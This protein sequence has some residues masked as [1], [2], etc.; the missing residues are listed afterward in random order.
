MIYF[1]V[2]AQKVYGVKGTSI[3][4]IF[5]WLD[6]L[7]F[8]AQVGGGSMIDP[9][10]SIKQQMLGIHIYMGGIGFQEFC[11]LLFLTIAIKFYLMM[12]VEERQGAFLDGRPKN[13]RMLLF[14]LF[15]A[16]VLI[17]IRIIF[18][19]VEF[20]SGLEA[21]KNPIPFH[22][23]YFM[24]LD[25]LPMTI[26]VLIFNV[27]HPGRVLQG[28]G[29]EFPKGPSRK[30]KKEIKRAKKEAKQMAKEE[31]KAA[32]QDGKFGTPMSDMV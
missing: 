19:L 23:A 7:S 10:N 16:L 21:D 31:K 4:K 17:T 1:F 12:R 18:R 29:S 30:E 3:A 14:A 22:E 11:M 27:I 15:A 28:E 13:W 6:V 9:T 8:L 25:A 24:C 5:V 20:A 32:K 26:C 2:P